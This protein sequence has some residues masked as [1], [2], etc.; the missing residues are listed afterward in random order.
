MEPSSDHCF[1]CFKQRTELRP[2]R[3]NKCHVLLI[4]IFKWIVQADFWGANDRFLIHMLR[5]SMMVCSVCDPEQMSVLFSNM[6]I[7]Y[8]NLQSTSQCK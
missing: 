6:V 5:L 3:A 7:S 8:L 4:Y 2:H 1:Y